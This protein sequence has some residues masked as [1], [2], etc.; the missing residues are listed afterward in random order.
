VPQAIGVSGDGI[1]PRPATSAPRTLAT[2][3]SPGG[4]DGI[5][6]G[7]SNSQPKMPA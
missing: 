4:S 7:P 5:G 3:Y 6:P 1:E 2:Q